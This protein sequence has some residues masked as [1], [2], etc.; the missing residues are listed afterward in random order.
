MP[1][2]LY[3]QTTQKHIQ[4]NKGMGSFLKSTEKVSG[5]TFS[6][7]VEIPV[8][9]NYAVEMTVRGTANVCLNFGSGDPDDEDFH[10]IDIV[11]CEMAANVIE[12]VQA[13]WEPI[14]DLKEELTKGRNRDHILVWEELE[15][16]LTTLAWERIT[17]K[18]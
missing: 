18:D 11:K 2:S 16:Q 10:E 3:H 8:F 15:R 6:T 12:G 4:K 5:L 1:V 14:H 7:V 9:Q 17:E 13:Y